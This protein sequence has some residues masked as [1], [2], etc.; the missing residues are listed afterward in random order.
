L[1]TFDCIVDIL[2]DSLCLDRAKIIREANLL[3]DL[4]V[5]SIDMLD[6]LFQIEHAF[7]VEMERDELFPD[8]L[9]ED[10]TDLVQAGRLTDAGVSRVLE[11]FP[12]LQADQ[13]PAEPKALVT[14]GFLVSFV[15]HRL[16]AKVAA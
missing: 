14:V 13:V 6:I 15:E 9:F 12:F 3:T 2:N 5:E 7:G 10:N 16:T 11:H 1:A 8:F 4:G